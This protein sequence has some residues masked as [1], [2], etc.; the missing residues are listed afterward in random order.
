MADKAHLPMCR[1][2]FEINMDKKMKKLLFTC[3]L[4]ASSFAFAHG[5]E[6]HMEKKFDSS[7]AEQTSFG[8]AADAQ[9]SGRKIKL[10]MD[11]NMRFTPGEIGIRKGETVTLV[12]T[13]KG[14][15]MHEAVLGGMPE[16]KAH[17]DMMRKFPA[18][19][20]EAPNMAHV[21]PGTSQ[22]IAWTFNK[23]GEF[24]FAC[25]IPGHFEAG[26]LGKIT[27]TQN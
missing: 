26:M 12:V 22:E 10:A 6:A 1:P 14:K 25:L 4:L 20:H 2:R 13:N 8:I 17:A 18:I 5:D 23:P 19:E 21:K 9:K 15:I 27:V 7:K 24:Y 16:L 11:D 3:L